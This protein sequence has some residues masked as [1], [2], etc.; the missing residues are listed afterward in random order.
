M[1]KIFNTVQIGQ[2]ASDYSKFNLSVDTLTTTDIG[3]LSVVHC[4]ECIIGDK[5]KVD[6]RLFGRTATL[7]F[8]TYGDIYQRLVSVF[9]PYYQLADDFEAW[10][11][12]MRFYGGR[13]A[14]PRYL[15]QSLLDVIIYGNFYKPIVSSTM[16]SHTMVQLTSAEAAKLDKSNLPR[17]IFEHHGENDTTT[18]FKLNTRGKSYYK[19][20][21]SLGYDFSRKLDFKR[22]VNNVVVP[23]VNSNTKLSIFPLLGYFKAFS[24][25]LLPSA[26]YQTSR[27]L[28]L[29]RGVKNADSSFV[30]PTGLVKV[31]PVVDALNEVLVAYYDSDYFTS[32]WQSPNSPLSSM[33]SMVN[34]TFRDEDNDV[35]MNTDS[36]SNRLT[37]GSTLSQTQLNFLRGFD[38]F[39]RRN[40]LVGFR[41][42]NAVYA[43]YGIK[44]SEMKSNYCQVIDID[45]MKLNV[46]DVTATA[47]TDDTLLGSYAGKAFQAGEKSIELECKDFGIF[48]QIAYI[49]VKPI[50]FQ[51]IR[52][53][54]LRVDP[55]DYYQPEFDGVGPAAISKRELNSQLP[56]EVFGFT[57]RYNDYRFAQ[58]N[59]LGDFELDE[60]M[61]PWHTGR[62]FKPDE[63]PIAQSDNVL[64]YRRDPFGNSEFDRIFAVEN[65]SIANDADHFYQTWT[66]NVTA[67]RK[68]KNINQALNLGVGNIQLDRNGSV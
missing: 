16:T 4:L 24:D 48:L 66:F 28:K 7:V 59:I 58:S 52:K 51:G 10:V 13:Q 45:S 49:G 27:V 60:L 15:T 11:S 41:E 18:Y 31:D 25:L 46:G 19:L 54:C 33:S 37:L 44:P 23:N 47:Q 43:R 65:S 26:R 6:Y 29:L 38:N 39:C 50:Y 64:T 35:T 55:Y 68:M 61:W 32:A 30:E 57:E 40:N 53:H 17:G 67:L 34:T 12:G 63:T 21:R 36:V 14:L 8:P 62:Y 1:S 22:K 3:E 42:F 9:V 20:F 5:I 56:D 2:A